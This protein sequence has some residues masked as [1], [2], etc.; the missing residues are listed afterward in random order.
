MFDDQINNKQVPG[1]LPIG[2][3]ALAASGLRRGEP[4]DFFAGSDGAAEA[5]QSAPRQPTALEKG[6]LKPKIE[7]GAVNSAGA[8]P[9]VPTMVTPPAEIYQVK[10]PALTRVIVTV[11]VVLVV[12]GI[13]G[14]GGWWVYN[15][16]IKTSLP[17]KSQTD[18]V[19]TTEPIAQPAEESSAPAVVEPEQAVVPATT[20]V[21]EEATTTTG[22]G[23]ENVAKE[24]ADEQVLFG[25]PIDKDGDG[26]DDA[27]EGEL[28]TDPNNWDTDGDALSDGDEV[29][30]WKTNPLNPDTDG[31]SYKDGSEVKNGYNPNGPGKI[32]EVPKE[33][34]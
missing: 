33:K 2:E 22:G 30:I 4:E 31:D 8:A 19:V 5:G 27:K 16:F 23:L 21:I 24:M 28:G 29:L 6:V 3:P 14:G 15:S 18:A 17:Q 26:L 10:E 9:E 12:L 7:D 13:L 11:V 32:F 25:E 34:K 20:E 1:N